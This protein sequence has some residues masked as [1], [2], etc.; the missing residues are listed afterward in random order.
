[1]AKLLGPIGYDVGARL[2]PEVIKSREI[3]WAVEYQ[4]FGF[5]YDEF[6][7]YHPMDDGKDSITIRIAD[8][9]KLEE[10]GYAPETSLWEGG[11]D[12][13]ILYE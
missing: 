6:G 8:A 7:N 1:M 2:E 13:A 9:K 3:P 12:S 10:M 11:V 5:D 4:G